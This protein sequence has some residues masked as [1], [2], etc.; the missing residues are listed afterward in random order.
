VI[1]FRP[2]RRKLAASVGI[3]GGIV[4]LLAVAYVVDGQPAALNPVALIAGGPIGDQGNEVSIRQQPDEGR[5]HVPAG[6]PIHYRNE[7]PSS[8]PHY[9]S[10]D[11][12]GVYGEPVAP[13]Y[14]VHNLEHGG[15]VV[16]YNCPTG[17]SEIVAEL[18]EAYR[19]FPNGEFGEVKLLIA[20]D[21]T[22]R[23]QVV[24]IAWNWVA[25]FTKF[26]V[27]DLRRFYLDHGEQG[28]ERFP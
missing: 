21:P 19:T 15:I 25:E 16:L 14:W 17:C 24:A 7:L 2:L 12:W 11:L 23:Y 18:A 10:P 26:N 1:G 8:G 6:S 13:G 22:L 27:D 9:P 20:P 4:V 5:D 3:L 28:P